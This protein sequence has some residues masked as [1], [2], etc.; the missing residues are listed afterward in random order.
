[1]ASL[2][3][4]NFPAIGKHGNEKPI[5]YQFAVSFR[6]GLLV[7]YTLFCSLDN[8]SGKKGCEGDNAFHFL[9]QCQ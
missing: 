9:M 7:S 3:V 5:C 8:Q 2:V 1:M 6:I 4:L